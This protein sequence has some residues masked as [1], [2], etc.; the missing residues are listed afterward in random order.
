[1]FFTYNCQKSLGKNCGRPVFLEEFQTAT[2]LS[3]VSLHFKKIPNS[4]R[5]VLEIY[6]EVCIFCVPQKR[7][8]E[9][10]SKD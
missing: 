10:V 7:P 9:A 4:V 2:T 8:P 5:Q 1:M 6:S 3:K